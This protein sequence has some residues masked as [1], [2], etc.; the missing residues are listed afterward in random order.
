MQSAR[1]QSGSRISLFIILSIP[2]AAFA[3]SPPQTSSSIKVTT[4]LVVLSV[5]V[6]DKSG[7][8]V[9]DLTKDDFAILENN[10]RQLIDTFEPPFAPSRAGKEILP[11]GNSAR[12][13]SSSA[14]TILV[15]DQLNTKS[16]DTMYTKV[17]VEKFLLAQPP[18]LSQPT[19]IFLLTKRRLELFAAPTRDR[20]SL[21]ALLKR[22]IIEL[23]PHYLESGGVQGGADRLLAS[24]LALD[25]IVL[26]M[27][28]QKVR[29]NVIWIGNGIPILSAN[30]ASL[31]DYD[32]F[33]NWVHYT[34]NWL[35][36]TQTTVYTI[37]PRGVEVAPESLSVDP[38]SAL[39]GAP[40]LTPS[41]LI[42]ESIAPESGGTSIRHRNDVD[43]AIDTAAREGASYYTLSY[44]PSNQNWD[45]KFRQ[46]RV[47]LARPELLARTHRGYYAFPDGFQNK[48]DQIEFG[49]SRAVTSPL[50]FRSV[51]FT[52]T[53]IIA[54]ER[55]R[56]P[57]P[58]KSSRTIAMPAARAILLIERDSLSWTPQPNGG[59]RTEVTLVTAAI[60]SSGRVL[61][62]RVR[63]LEVLLAKS[64]LEGP[65]SNDPLQLSVLVDLPGKTDHLR[66]V[67]RDAASGHL[68]TFD[69]P[70]STL[71]IANATPS[72]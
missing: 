50:P 29:K 45:G 2:F 3:Q 68:G 27:A 62:Y 28:D 54:T 53:G 61:G 57:R 32:R 31:G 56:A 9:T 20:D 60:S 51:T 33:T 48:G 64:K 65:S 63:E 42:F 19:S 12:V 15:L 38:R 30:N 21:L 25:E 43:V 1:L 4:R 40:D 22:P 18:V 58:T 13:N 6:T 35:E 16:E 7:N 8:P 46:I 44:Y 10:Q 52:A 49:L 24:L 14:R 17:K 26:S 47:S 34:S 67:L 70:A 71:G 11:A 37:D 66:M 69:L 39:I 5:V 36:E 41:E 72:R 23:P 55:L 59:Q